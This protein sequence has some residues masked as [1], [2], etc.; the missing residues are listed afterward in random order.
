MLVTARY[1]DK[2][3]KNTQNTKNAKKVIML[4]MLRNIIKS[5]K[6]LQIT[7]EAHLQPLDKDLV[8]N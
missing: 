7:F 5:K 3:Y 6:R 8:E 4:K 2:I 1:L